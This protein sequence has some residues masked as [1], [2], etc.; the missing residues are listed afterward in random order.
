[1]LEICNLNYLDFKNFNLKIEKNSYTSIVGSNKSGKTTLCKIISGLLLIDNV[2]E[3]NNI[4][5][6]KDNVYKYV[7][8]IGVVSLVNENSFIYN[9]VKDELS[10]PL[11]NLHYPKIIVERIIK[12]MLQ[13]FH[14]TNIYDKKISELDISTKQVLLFVIALLHKPKVLLIDEG[15][16]LLNNDEKKR[17]N[18][19]LNKRKKNDLTIVNF[20]NNLYNIVNSDELCLLEKFA[21]KKTGKPM[22]LLEDDQLFYQI[23]LEVPFMIDLSIK[24]KMYNLIDKVHLDMEELVNN[25]WK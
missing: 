24:L 23:G 16:L 18:E 12:E 13:D 15:F 3:C 7:R 2:C 14:L 1:M 10:Y 20:T 11:L 25:I 21:I 8:N 22:E 17:V 9:N 6:N 19:Y 4:K 5:L